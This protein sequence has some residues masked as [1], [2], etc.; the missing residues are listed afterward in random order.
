LVLEAKLRHV[1]VDGNNSGG[2]YTQSH[3]PADGD[4]TVN[5]EHEQRKVEADKGAVVLKIAT[6]CLSGAST[7]IG[8]EGQSV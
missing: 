4:A 1:K 6:H 2:K 5:E 7:V 3:G 8:E